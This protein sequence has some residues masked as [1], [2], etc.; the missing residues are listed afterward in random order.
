MINTFT[1]RTTMQ[2]HKKKRKKKN[3]K[4]QIEK[5]KKKKKKK[6]EQYISLKYEYSGKQIEIFSF[7]EIIYI[8]NV[9]TFFNNMFCCGCERKKSIKANMI[10]W[11]K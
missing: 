1:L 11:S 8:Y 6:S 5:R 7:V 3:V 10:K 2:K 9:W 4:H